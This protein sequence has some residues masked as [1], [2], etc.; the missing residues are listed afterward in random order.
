MKNTPIGNIVRELAV[1]LTKGDYKD[2]TSNGFFI[3]SAAAG[4]IKYVPLNN[5]DAE[6]ITKTVDAQAYFN[7]P[8]LCRTIVASG[9]TATGIYAGY[10][11]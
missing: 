7:D 3:R 10:G 9:T 11:V 2:E 8:T 4:V 5:S 1:D 6:I